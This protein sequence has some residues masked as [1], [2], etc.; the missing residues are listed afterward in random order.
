MHGIF[1]GFVE[2]YKI[3]PPVCVFARRCHAWPS[4][5]WCG[6]VCVCA[7]SLSL[8]RKKHNGRYRQQHAVRRAWNSKMRS[9][10]LRKHATTNS[11]SV[12]NTDIRTSCT[13]KSKS[14]PFSSDCAGGAVL[15]RPCPRMPMARAHIHSVCVF[16]GYRF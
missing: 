4:S 11:V 9:T 5:R 10:V 8:P 7:R 16:W 3:Q 13:V 14:G 15:P 6:S 2:K 12:I 1:V